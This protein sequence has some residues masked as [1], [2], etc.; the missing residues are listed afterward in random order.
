MI[1]ATAIAACQCLK[2]PSNCEADTTAELSS[3]MPRCQVMLWFDGGALLRNQRYEKKDY[4]SL[5]YSPWFQAK[6]Y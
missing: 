1:L 3:P 2:Q 4:A 6:L 5:D